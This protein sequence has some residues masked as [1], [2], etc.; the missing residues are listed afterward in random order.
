MN[1]IFSINLIIMMIMII[2]SSSS[3]LSPPSYTEGYHDTVQCGCFCLMCGNPPCLLTEIELGGRKYFLENI[4]FGIL[5]EYSFLG[6][7]Q[8]NMWQPPCLLTEIE[9]SDRNCIL[10]NI[11]WGVSHE[12]SFF[13]RRSKICGNPC[14]CS[15][16][17]SPATVIVF[18]II[19]GGFPMNILFWEAFENMWQPHVCSLRL[20]PATIIIFLKISFWGF[21]MNILFWKAFKN[22]WQTPCLFIEIERGGCKYNL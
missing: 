13:W 11:F 8:K 1:I 10:E 16:R 2:L 22:M 17:L 15:P 20:S 19:L 14:V 4:L 21:C 5:H 6:G 12:Y 18:M 9:L 3:P 7:I